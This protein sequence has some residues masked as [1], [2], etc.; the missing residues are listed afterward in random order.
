MRVTLLASAAFGVPTLDTLLSHGHEVSVGTQP[1]R[2][3]GRGRRPQP[4]EVAHHAHS[5]GL[6][7]F[8]LDDV[9][10]PEGL[11]WLT[12]SVPDI[13]VVVAFGQK[14]G[15]AVRAAAPW[16]CVN[17]HPSLLPRWRGA[18]PVNHTILAGDERTGVCVIDVVE[19]MDA[20]AILGR[21]ETDVD[22]K[23]AGEL[24]DELAL[25]GANLLVRLIDRMAADEIERIPQDESRVTRAP[26]LTADD[27]RIRWEHDAVDVDRRVRAVTP[28]PGAF[29]LVEDVTRL[30]ILAGEPA[31]CP[32]GSLPGEIVEASEQGVFVACG[33]GAY[34]ITR[35]QREGGR[36]LDAAEYLRGHALPAGAR[37]GP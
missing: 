5:L 17:I 25:A 26:K 12:S 7:A 15:P 6:P 21:V 8:E 3:A 28:R 34:R 24:L 23:T 32:K 13:V 1:A 22:R 2:P 33:R 20:G 37:L 18:A 30:R 4:T 9:N 36:P 35:L 19:R 10:G 31:A 16:G 14:L 29:A 27:G 11:R